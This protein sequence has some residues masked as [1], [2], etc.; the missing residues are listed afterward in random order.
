MQ[1][2]ASKVTSFERRHKFFGYGQIRIVMKEFHYQ[3]MMRWANRDDP[4]RRPTIEKLAIFFSFNPTLS[5]LLG[6]V[7]IG[8]EKFDDLHATVETTLCFAEQLSPPWF[9]G[10]RMWP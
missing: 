7:A 8:L 9:A 3:A 5:F 2:L 4:D 1:V 10:I 6:G